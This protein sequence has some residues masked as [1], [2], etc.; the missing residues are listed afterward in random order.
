M[1][2]GCDESMKGQWMRTES[3]L[4][5]E[6]GAQ[7]PLSFCLSPTRAAMILSSRIGQLEL[8]DNN[9]WIPTIS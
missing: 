2:R 3:F 4:E 8:S 5:E 1:E 6:P 7:V 9:L